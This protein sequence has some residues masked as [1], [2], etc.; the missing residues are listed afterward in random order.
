MDGDLV[1]I[2]P[3][4]L[5]TAARSYDAVAAGIGA[6]PPAEPGAAA[7]FAATAVAVALAGD[8]DA[9]L[10]RDRRAAHE[11]AEALRGAAGAWRDTDTAVAAELAA[12]PGPGG[13]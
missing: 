7:G 13:P 2:R 11:L 9:E 6:A 5:D 4:E 8:R 10:H 3:D 12:R 1:R